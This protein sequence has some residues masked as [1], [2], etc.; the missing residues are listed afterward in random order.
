[1]IIICRVIW[2]Y[3][4]LKIL[5]CQTIK[6]IFLVINSSRCPNLDQRPKSWA[7]EAGPVLLALLDA[8]LCRKQPFCCHRDFSGGKNRKG[9]SSGGSCVAWVNRCLFRSQFNTSRKQTMVR[10]RG[11]DNFQR[12]CT[13]SSRNNTKGEVWLKRLAMEGKLNFKTNSKDSRK[14]HGAQGTMLAMLTQHFKG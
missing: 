10:T 2:R 4:G 14:D 3:C 6:A 13:C 9:L 8:V 5:I 1:M 12:S 11:T 7:R